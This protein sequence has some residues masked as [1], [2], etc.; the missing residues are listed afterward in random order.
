MKRF[1]QWY[2]AKNLPGKY[3]ALNAVHIE[4]FQRANCRI[5]EYNSL[6]CP[7]HCQ[8]NFESKCNYIIY[9]V[10]AKKYLPAFTPFEHAQYQ[11]RI[12]NIMGILMEIMSQRR[13]VQKAIVACSQN[14]IV[15]LRWKLSEKRVGVVRKLCKHNQQELEAMTWIRINRAIN[16][17]NSSCEPRAIS[18]VDSNSWIYNIWTS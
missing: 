11:C 15:V 9:C 2:G 3:V 12:G 10:L 16:G 1:C 14:C 13:T 7:K 17:L 4:T 8:W 6:S 5:L 18:D